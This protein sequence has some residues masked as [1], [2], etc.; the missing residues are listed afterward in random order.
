M[1]GMCYKDLEN[2]DAED[3][4]LDEA[5]EILIDI[6]GLPRGWFVTNEHDKMPPSVD[7]GF[8]WVVLVRLSDMQVISVSND[9]YLGGEGS[10]D[11]LDDIDNIEE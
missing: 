8:P 2:P 5:E 1:V 9:K 11:I 7:S 6:D 10:G 4:S 3:L